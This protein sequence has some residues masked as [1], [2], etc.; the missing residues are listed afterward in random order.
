MLRRIIKLSS[1]LIPNKQ[2]RVNFRNKYL[3]S[4]DISNS[5]Q[6]KNSKLERIDNFLLNVQEDPS[7][8]KQVTKEF[9]KSVEIGIH[10][11][12][13]RKCWFCANANIVDR[14]SSKVEM[15]EELFLKIISELSEINYDKS[16]SFHRFNEPLAD[17]DLLYKRIAQVKKILPNS[18]PTIFSNGDYIKNISEI[19]EL[20]ELGI[21][22]IYISL[23][24]N[25]NENFNDQET[26]FSKMDSFFKKIDG[27]YEEIQFD[28]DK[29]IYFSTIK[30]FKHKLIVVVPNFEDSAF[31]M[32]GII[33]SQNKKVEKRTLPCGQ[34]FMGIWVDYHS[35]AMP[36]CALRKEI[37]SHEYASIG[38]VKDHTIFELFT[39]EKMV[40]FRRSVRNHGFKPGACTYCD[41]DDSWTTEDVPIR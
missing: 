16:I 32:G 28:S 35:Y 36:C 1:C 30:D 9:L 31:T 11:F 23:Y 8:Q 26:V 14:H 12:C 3:S 33:D 15:P 10:S 40:N 4:P 17:K 19:K 41:L 20:L 6:D 21:S 7:L 37:E 5:N 38:N 39:N 18:T 13:N 27:E 29:Q 2:K 24:L 34:A 25:K 22:S